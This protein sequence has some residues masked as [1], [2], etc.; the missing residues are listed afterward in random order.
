MPL[1]LPLIATRVGGKG[2]LRGPRRAD[3]ISSAAPEPARGARIVYR[4]PHPGVSGR[5]IVTMDSHTPMELRVTAVP[6][7]MGDNAGT[8]RSPAG[9]PVTLHCNICQAVAVGL[10]G[11][12]RR[13]YGQAAE[14]LVL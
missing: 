12:S 10:A 9:S 11:P 1:I 7:P 4:A 8:L 6:L 5:A 2:R 3:N 14:E 13:R